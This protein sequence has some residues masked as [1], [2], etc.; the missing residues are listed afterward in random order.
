MIIDI[1]N[2]NM[3][4]NICSGASCVVYKGTYKY[5]DVAIKKI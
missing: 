5:L 1:K 2:F 3:G 4:V